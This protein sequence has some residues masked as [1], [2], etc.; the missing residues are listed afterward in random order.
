MP[1]SIGCVFKKRKRQ[2]RGKKDIELGED[3]LSDSSTQNSTVDS[4]AYPQLS[5]KHR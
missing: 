5:V 1:R 3:R 4:D 2:F